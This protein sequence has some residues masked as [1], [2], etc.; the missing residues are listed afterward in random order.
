[1]RFQPFGNAF[2]PSSKNIILKGHPIIYPL[3]KKYVCDYNPRCLMSIFLM[4]DEIIMNMIRNKELEFH[5]EVVD[6]YFTNMEN[7]IIYIYRG[8]LQDFY[9]NKVTN[10]SLYIVCPHFNVEIIKMRQHFSNT[11]K[12]DTSS[13]DK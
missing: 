4:F 11:L 1:M 8:S 10:K 7:N 5:V 9:W 2:L 3:K 6:S 13:D 12:C